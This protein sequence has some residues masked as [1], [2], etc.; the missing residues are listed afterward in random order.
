MVIEIG[1]AVVRT[2]RITD[3]AIRRFV[4]LSGD[5]NPVHSDDERNLAAMCFDTWRWQMGN[6]QGYGGAVEAVQ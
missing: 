2:V 4:A 6:P 3:E 5:R 1:A